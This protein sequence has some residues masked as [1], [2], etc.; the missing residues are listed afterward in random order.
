M[1]VEASLPLFQIFSD[2]DMCWV[3][4]DVSMDLYAKINVFHVVLSLT[5]RFVDDC[6]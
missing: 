6:E 4:N 5:W 2:F 3:M 1:K